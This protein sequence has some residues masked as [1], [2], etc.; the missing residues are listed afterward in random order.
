MRHAALAVLVVVLGILLVVPASAQKSFSATYDSERQVKLEG[1]V[2][3]ID[4][5][6]PSAYLLI[7]VKDAGGTITN[8]AVEFGNPLELVEA[9][10]A[11][12]RARCCDHLRWG[13]RQRMR[14]GGGGDGPIGGPDMPRVS[15]GVR[16]GHRAD[17]WLAEPF[18]WHA[19]SVRVFLPGVLATTEKSLGRMTNGSLESS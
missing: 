2:T 11:M 13:V 12:T 6:N 7:D 17:R 8:W 1:I 16:C 3:R 4:W 19:V 14:C 9:I 15:G 10:P 5:V 18:G